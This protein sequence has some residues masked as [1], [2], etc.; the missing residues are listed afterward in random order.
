MIT[1]LATIPGEVAFPIATAL[2]GAIMAMG[3]AIQV[4]YEN[5]R[6][7]SRESIS[8][9]KDTT[10]AVE[11]LTETQQRVATFVESIYLDSQKRDSNDH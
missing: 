9:L 7:D 5:G 11:R 10:H 4:M 3:K 1:L 8:A 6:K 2:G